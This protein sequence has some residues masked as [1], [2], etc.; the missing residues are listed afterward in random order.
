MI[1]VGLYSNE[2]IVNEGTGKLIR[3][4]QLYESEKSDWF[5]IIITNNFYCAYHDFQLFF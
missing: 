3:P 5:S 2:V 4:N 1:K